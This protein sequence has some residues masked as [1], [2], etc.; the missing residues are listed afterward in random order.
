MKRSSKKTIALTLLLIVAVPLC[1]TIFLQVRQLVIR[2]K[3]M[4]MLEKENLI[5]V[6]IPQ[7]QIYW[8]KTNKE[9]IHN[10][11]MF[12]VKSWINE[13]GYCTFTG[14]Y[15]DDETQ[16]AEKMNN[17]TGTDN[18][19]QHTTLTQL[20]QLLMNLYY[21]PGGN[22]TLYFTGT[23]YSIKKTKLPSQFIS[24]IT[25]PPKV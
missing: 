24:I 20:F 5:T 17:K 15:D 9:L 23:T 13:N 16:L 2:H 6:T 10:S 1:C 18:F 22:N 4:E 3:M 19:T 21:Q 14:L 25:P 8:I 12:D 7:N 11:R